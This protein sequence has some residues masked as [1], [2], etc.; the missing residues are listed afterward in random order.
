M[1]KSPE[2]TKSKVDAPQKSQTQAM[3]V[4][5]LAASGRGD[6]RAFARLY[7][8]TCGRLYAIALRLLRRADWAEEVLQESYV[9]IWH[10]AAGYQSGL[11]QP[12]TWMTSIVRNG[13]LDWLRRPQIEVH[14]ED[15]NF[16]LQM[17]A[18]IPV[19]CNCWKLPATPGRWRAVWSNSKKIPAA[20]SCLPSSRA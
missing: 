17:E 20:R 11:S 4:E 18:R 8:L 19:R 5:L 9:K 14:D 12:L 1:R 13:C 2:N 16:A 3:L 7:E 6:E 15:D 10:H